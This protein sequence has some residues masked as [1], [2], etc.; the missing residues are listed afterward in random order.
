MHDAQ[1]FPRFFVSNLSL[2]LA[3]LPLDEQISPIEGPRNFSLKGSLCFVLVKNISYV[4]ECIQLY[5]QSA[6]WFEIPWDTPPYSVNAS[7]LSGWWPSM[8]PTGTPSR[9]PRWA[10]FCIG[11]IGGDGRFPWTGCQSREVV[12]AKK[13]LFSFSPNIS[14]VFNATYPGRNFTN[15]DPR[16]FSVAN[17]FDVWLLCGINGSCTD[18]SPFAM[19]GGGVQGVGRF[20]WSSST[21]FGD[22]FSPPVEPTGSWSNLRIPG[23]FE[24]FINTTFA[25]T[26][27]C[28]WPPFVW[29]VGN[30]S[31][32]EG[33]LPCSPNTCFYTL[34]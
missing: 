30:A 8:D 25:P 12:W 4:G 17:P 27:V 11:E 6:A 20:N 32:E 26:P 16:T 34:C 28:V 13:D 22:F 31:M 18:L 23:K 2:N 9:Q 1:V 15:Q 21:P 5:N 3:Y 14:T 33:M 10:P 19:V 7:Y 29:L 24:S